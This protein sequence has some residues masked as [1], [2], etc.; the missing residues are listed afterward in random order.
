MKDLRLLVW[1][2]QLGMGIAMP[3]AGFTLAGVWLKNRFCLGPWVV[4]A[5]C[6]LGLAC[7]VRAFVGS[8]RFLSQQQKEKDPKPPVAFNKHE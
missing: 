4:V 2:T 3:M 8:L 1:I 7:A 6:A 5:G